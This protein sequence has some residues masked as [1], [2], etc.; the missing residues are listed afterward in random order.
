MKTRWAVLFFLLAL[1][2]AM[3][4]TAKK[5]V[6]VDSLAATVDNETITIED[7]EVEKEILRRTKIW[8]SFAEPPAQVTDKHAF[9]EVI[10]RKLLYIQ[11]RKMGFADVPP[12][13]VENAVAQ[14]RKTFAGTQDYRSWLEKYEY[15]DPSMKQ[16]AKDLAR[17]RLIAKRFYRRLVIGNYLRKKIDVQV[18]LGLNGYIEEH[19][20]DLRRETPGASEEELHEV[21]RQTLYFERLSEHIAELQDRSNVVIIR[22]RY[23]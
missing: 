4:A 12:E 6:M 17:Y 21:A 13:A 5:P 14:F 7:I 23:L 3:P 15:R 22:D 1:T 10:S 16:E 20:A 11:A 9:R 8:F 2:I 18:K 19:G